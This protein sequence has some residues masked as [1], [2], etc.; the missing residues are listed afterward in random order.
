MNESTIGVEF[1]EDSLSL[2]YTV[3]IELAHVG[4]RR[5]TLK[6]AHSQGWQA[7]AG[8][9]LAALPGLWAGGLR[10]S[11]HGLLFHDWLGFLTVWPLSSKNEHL[12]RTMHAFFFITLSV[13]SSIVESMLRFKG[14]EHRPAA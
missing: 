2:F 7:G 14:R 13:T 3:S 4:V 10:S 11:L 1:G 8:C 12:K 6:R 5:P 9:W